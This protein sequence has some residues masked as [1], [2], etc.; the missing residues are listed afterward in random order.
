MLLTDALTRPPEFAMPVST[1]MQEYGEP[2]A[3]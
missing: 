3:T 1:R 2:R